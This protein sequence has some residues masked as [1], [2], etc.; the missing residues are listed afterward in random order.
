M[1]RLHGSPRQVGP[2]GL[3]ANVGLDEGGNVGQEDIHPIQILTTA[4]HGEP[5]RPRPRGH[6][7]PVPALVSADA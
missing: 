6:V 5:G 2:Q 1:T 7:P 4:G 3:V